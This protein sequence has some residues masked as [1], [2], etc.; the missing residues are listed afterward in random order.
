M[1]RIFLCSLSRGIWVC[2]W[3]VLLLMM[4]GDLHAQAATPRITEAINDSSRVALK[5]NVPAIL[6]SAIDQGMASDTTTLSHVRLVLQRSAE[7]EANLKQYL[8][9]LQQKSSPNYHKW[10]TPEEFGKLYGPADSDIAAITGWLESQGLTIEA[11]SKG[12][13]DIAFSGTVSVIQKAFQTSIHSYSLNGQQF[14]SNDSLPTIPSALSSVVSGVT[15]LS[16]LKPR[17][18][19]QLGRP[20]KYDSESKSLRPVS[21]TTSSLLHPQ[22]TYTSSSD[23]YLYLVPGDAATIYN[24]PNTTLNAN[25]TSGTSYTGSGITIG[26]VGDAYLSTTTPITNYRGLF[27]GESS[28]TAPKV[29]NVD[30]NTDTT[31]VDETYLDIEVAGALA[32]GATIHYYQSKDLYSAISQAINDNVIDIL[33][34]SYGQCELGYTTSFNQE[35]EGWWKQAAA[36]GIAVTVSSGDNGSAACDDPNSQTKAEYGLQVNGLGST[37]YNISVGGTDF[38]LTQSNFSTY[39]ST[40]NSSSTYYRTAKSYIPEVTWNDSTS[41]NTTISANVPYSGTSANIWAGS[42][43]KSGCAQNTNTSATNGTCSAGWSKPSWQAGT[44]VPSDGVRDLPDISLM[45][46]AGSTYYAAWLV[47]TNDTS[48]GYTANCGSSS[49]SFSFYGMGGTSAAAPAFAGILALVQQSQGGGRL[50]QAA[51][52]LYNIYNNSSNVSQIFHDITTGNISVPCD[53]ASSYGNCSKNSA[54]YYFLTGYEAGT[55]YDMATGLGSVN[56]MQLINNWGSGT[57]TSTATITAT[58]ASTSITTSNS[59]NVT[60]TVSGSSGTPSGS[61]VLSS[62]TYQSSAVN[63]NSGTASITIPAGSLAAGIDTITA[64]Y[65]GDGIYSSGTATTTVTVTAT[66]LTSTTT[67]LTASSTAITYGSTVTF[68]ATVSPTAATGTVTFYNGSSALGSASLSSG[69]A[70]Y[71]TTSLPVGTN[72]VTATYAGDSTYASSTSSA[73]IVTVSSSSTSSSGSFSLSATDVSVSQGASGTSTVTV[74]PSNGYTGTVALTISTSSSS[75]SSNACF[76][77]TYPTVTSTST[78]TTIITIY[79]SAANCSSAS[80][81]R[82]GVHHSFVRRETRSISAM[83][84]NTG[85]L[86][87]RSL[88]ISAAAILG[89]FLPGLRR[90]RAKI[91]G[92][93]SCLVLA[94]LAWGSTGCGSSSS[95]NTVAKGTYTLVLDGTASSSS[96]ITAETSFTLTVK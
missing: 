47:C 31:D 20:G 80:S 45:S 29:T 7:Q 2:S 89:L 32:P 51:A 15:H 13:T 40:S 46:G 50:G 25:Y 65:S 4:A 83:H 78:V 53:S 75:V 26:T 9:E 34:L 10:L 52:N 23:Y 85:R 48:S 69:T 79:T 17:P 54:G 66:S 68:A 43:G 38:K 87:S 14:Y 94:A 62:G 6:R 30:S 60:V 63:L 86:L 55:G 71:S 35:I 24:T 92:I 77:V 70:T 42:G 22:L 84:R 49:G 57:G 16:T 76:D 82:G 33:S 61:V 11:I 5:G 28:P 72:T 88:P 19:Y 18:F 36:Q 58:P 3:V 12:R 93:L 56:V 95:S 90:R 96:S 44:G 67:L 73:V 27:L 64:T 41:N 91:L 59:L 39:V 8:A 81:V 21:S 74:T 1:R 37:P